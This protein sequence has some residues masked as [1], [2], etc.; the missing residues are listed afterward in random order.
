MPAVPNKAYADTANNSVS[1]SNLDTTKAL[2]D[3]YANT[4]QRDIPG[5]ENISSLTG[6]LN[7]TETDL[8]FPGRNGLDVSLTRIYSSRDSNLT[9]PKATTTNTSSPYYYTND[10]TSDKYTHNEKRYN[11]G[12][13]WSFAFPSV[14]LRGGETFLHLA[15]GNV[16]RITGTGTTRTIEGYTLQDMT[17]S[18]ATDTIGGATAAFK[19]SN[20]LNTANY[21]DSTGKWIGTRD[22]YG[23]EV[24]VAYVSKPIFGGTSASVI[25]AI[26]STGNRVIS[27]DYPD[28]D[29]VAVTYPIDGTKTGKLVYN[30]SAISGQTNEMQ[31]SSVDSFINIDTANSSNNKKL[32]TAYSY[33]SKSAAFDYETADTSKPNG[34]ITYQL[35]TKITYPTGASSN[36]GYEAAAQKKFLG[37][38]GYLEYYRIGERYDSLKG[39]TGTVQKTQYTKYSFEAGKNFSGYGTAGESNPDSLSSGFTIKNSMRTF[40]D[41]DTAVPT[42]DRLLESFTYNNKHLLVTSS[43][44]KQGEYKENKVYTYDPQRELP[45]NIR[46]NLYSIDGTDQSSFTEEQ[47]TY[48]NYGNVLTYINPKNYKTTYSYHSTFK[49]I[50]ITKETTYGIAT[51]SPVAEKYVQTV[52]ATKP[53][54]TKSEQKYKNT[55]ADTVEQTDTTEYTYDTYGNVLTV[56]LLLENNRSQL[57]T[58]TYDSNSLFPVSVKQNVTKNGT[59][60]SVEEKYEYTSG[61]GWQKGYL[62]PNAVKA[63]TSAAASR[64]YETEYDLIGRVTKIRSSMNAGESVK[65]ER[66]FSYTYDTANQSYTVQ[67]MD[68]EGNKTSS[69]YDGLGRIREVKAPAA[70]TV[71]D[72]TTLAHTPATKQSYTYNGLGE[73]IGVKDGLNHTTSY[74]YDNVGRIK[75]TTTPLGQIYGSSYNDM[76]RSI[77]TTSPIT[78]TTQAVT[79]QTTDE[80][81]RMTNV[82]QL[83]SNPTS[84]DVLQRS[85]AYEVGSDPFQI[86]NT[87]SNGNQTTYQGNGLGL[88][89]NLEQT[90]NGLSQTSTYGYNKLRQITSKQV[91]GQILT[92]Y[93]YDERGQRI[94]KTDSNEGTE[95]YGYD[96]NGNL[97]EGTDRLGNPAQH[98]Y[99]ERN[100][101]TG[102]NYGAAGNAVTA[103]FTYYKNGLRKSM[104]DETGT[105]QYLYNRDST[106][107]KVTFPD[108]KTIQYE[109]DNAGNR[110]K[111]TDPFGAITLYTYDDDN[112]LTKVS[113]K[114]N[115]TSAEVTQASYT[116]SGSV[117]DKVT[118]GNGIVTQ[119]LYEDGFGRLT[120]LKHLKGTE[121]L[122]EYNY[123]YD[124]NGNIT[125]RTSNGNTETFTYDELDR[126]ISSSEGNEQYGYDVKG[127]RTVQ[128]STASSPHTDTMEYSYDGANQLKQVTRNGFTTSYK[129]DGDGLMREKNDGGTTRYYYDGENIIAEGS[130]SGNTVNFK[131]R[132]VRGLQLISM[133]NQWGTVGYYLQNGHG[134]VVNLYRQ[135]QTL[136]NTYDYDIWGNPTVKEE[137]DQYTNPFRYSGEYWDEGQQLQ[138]LRARWYDPSVGRFITEDTWEGRLNHPDSQ[139]PYIYVVNNPLKYV[140]PSGQ[141][142]EWV[143]VLLA[144]T[145]GSGLVA[146][147]V[148]LF[149]GGSAKEAA[150][151]GLGA[152]GGAALT[153]TLLALAGPTTG[154]INIG[155]AN[156]AGSA[157]AD[158]IVSSINNDQLL[159]PEFAASMIIS[160]VA[161]QIRNDELSLYLD[162]LISS[163][164]TY[165]E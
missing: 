152:A 58:Y 108:G 110:A 142:A 25:S 20:T 70:N 116:Y 83:N 1:L 100:Q 68:E 64:K 138:Y 147:T 130:V 122:N 133:K 149:K 38:K 29:T 140:D 65:P 84:S 73:V 12:A 151:E 24:T 139:N 31:L 4:P 106:L 40:T 62:D 119:Y 131:A 111:M 87:D 26:T 145:I 19:L 89:T 114:E 59:T 150:I 18:T 164:R 124:D 8:V 15:N 51:G 34:A 47:Y 85:I 10:S 66:T 78:A 79:E 17:F 49:S 135:D 72:S 54:V 141:L 46:Q 127:N 120:E 41:P 137:A 71:M 6:V 42:Q 155:L 21:F 3:I 126:I 148:E 9:N 14:E 115:S 35:L 118:L 57:T 53:E 33:A 77:T 7:V 81:G 16:Y 43:A 90:I 86:Q 125:Q 55:L 101:L 5:G 39:P 22:A 94:S 80:L 123:T 102:W 160:S 132:Y 61:T 88:L 143:A 104:T 30:K 63:G 93:D 13:G 112:R 27:F 74:E 103:S 99:D 128:L 154:F 113:L 95:T 52:S 96:D 158:M 32:T 107:R 134:D 36:Y 91:E 163:L 2:Y 37:T 82:K 156:A 144:T 121:V 97:V 146:F 136:L 165:L 162:L 129:Y 50:P 98:S 48:D 161:G 67:G 28:A 23:N 157:F 11:L 75:Q 153:G 60:R 45:S 117:L 44:E 105:T 56:K 76:L 109:Y 159:K 92:T 69:L